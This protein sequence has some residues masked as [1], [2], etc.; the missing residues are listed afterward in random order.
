M[1]SVPVFVGLDYSQAFVQVCVLDPQGKVLANSPRP[2]TWADIAA[3]VHHHGTAVRAAI[4][5]CT[6]AADLAAE[7]VEQAGWSVALAHP[8]YVAR[9]KQSPDKTDYQDARLLAD[10]E[11]VGYLPRVWLPPLHIREL[12]KLVRHR[13]TLAAQRRAVKLRLRALLRD[14][15]LP[16]PACTP[17]TQAWR[18][19]LTQEAT[20]PEHSRWLVSEHLAELDHVQQRLAAVEARL[21]A[22]TKDDAIVQ[23][24]LTQP[25]VGP[26]TAWTLR[27][28][29]GDFGRFRS[30]KQLARYCGLSPQ[31]VSSG[32]RQADAGLIRVADPALRSTL[33]EAG[34]RLARYDPQWKGR[35]A[36][37]R[38]AGKPYNVIVAAVANRWVRWLYHQV[39]AGPAAA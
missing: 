19:W 22:A 12:R 36:A 6:G 27:A 37:W 26:V 3:L 17:W 34:Q 15:R 30:G 35:V 20:L 11:R 18:R 38:Q 13:Q 9:L 10:L 7:L 32:T 31:N 25:G 1:A 28:A 16:A 4:E 23:W 14:H 2:N 29:I 8:G 33:I 24:L 39:L 5:S 21:A